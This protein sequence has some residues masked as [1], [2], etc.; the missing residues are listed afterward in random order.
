[1]PIHAA[2]VL[3]CPS[4]TTQIRMRN[5]VLERSAD[6]TAASGIRF[7]V[8]GFRNSQLGLSSDTAMYHTVCVL[9]C[10]M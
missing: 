6:P 10:T 4:E 8:L 9:I 7:L 2:P 5:F 1:M 3:L